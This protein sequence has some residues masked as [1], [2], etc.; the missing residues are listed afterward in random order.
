M[1]ISIRTATPE[2]Y[3]AILGLIKELAEFEKEPDQVKNSVAQMHDEDDHFEALVVTENDVVIGMALYFYAYFTWVGKS[4]WLDD[5]YVKPEYRG[6]GIA[7]QL[8]EQLKEIARI[9]GCKQIRWQVL[10]W[11]ENAIKLYEKIGAQ[12]DPAWH[13]CKIETGA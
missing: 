11:N 12:L 8:I 2:D 9:K 13:I 6:H 1:T 10:E 3:P 5:L 4:M 7:S